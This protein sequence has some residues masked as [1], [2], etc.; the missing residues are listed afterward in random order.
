MEVNIRPALTQ[1]GSERAIHVSYTLWGDESDE[2]LEIIAGH[3]PQ[4]AD[5][6]ARKNAEYQD[7]NGGAFTLGERGQ[8]SDMYRKM[9]KLKAALW[10]GNEGQLSTESVEEILMDMIGH[11]LLTLE[12]RRRAAGRLGIVQTLYQNLDKQEEK[13]TEGG[14]PALD[15]EVLF[16]Y[17]PDEG[18]QAFQREDGVFF[19]IGQLVRLK[20]HLGKGPIF[21]IAS[22][23]VSAQMDVILE[24]VEDNAWAKADSQFGTKSEWLVPLETQTEPF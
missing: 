11:C 7:N 12:M 9:I 20:H 21:R 10:D 8:F 17:T 2:M 4:W 16:S 18:P 6:F 23:D 22:F 14:E 1:G 3:L 19:S 5:L 15:D 13:N 24:S